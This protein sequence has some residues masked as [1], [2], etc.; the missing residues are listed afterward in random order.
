MH[1]IDDVPYVRIVETDPA[2]R[3]EEALEEKK[4]AMKNGFL[5]QNIIFRAVHTE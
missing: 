4:K 2:V 3:M 5:F 1:R